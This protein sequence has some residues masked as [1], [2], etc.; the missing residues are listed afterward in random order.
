MCKIFTKLGRYPVIFVAVGKF[1]QVTYEAAVVGVAQPAVNK[2]GQNLD[3]FFQPDTQ[4]RL[5]KQ[6]PEIQ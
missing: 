5:L 3:E 4:H 2:L 6:R 1:D